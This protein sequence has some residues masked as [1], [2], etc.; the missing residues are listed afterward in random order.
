MKIKAYQL[1][2]EVCEDLNL[3]EKDY[4]GLSYKDKENI[5]V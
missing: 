2:D 5:K 4:F 1:F 3:L